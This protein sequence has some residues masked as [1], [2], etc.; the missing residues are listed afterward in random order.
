L[1]VALAFALVLASAQG[2]VLWDESVSGDLSNTQSSPTSIT[3][4]AGQNS[5]SGTVGLS[6]GQDWVTLTVPGGLQL[7]SLTLAVYA[8]S[9]TQGFIGV[10]S[11]SV[12]GGSPDNPASYLGYAHFGTAASNGALPTANLVGSDLLPIMGNTAAAPGS[13]GFTAPLGSGDYS[14]LIQ[15]LGAA[16]TYQFDY[17]VTPIPEVNAQ[18]MVAVLCAVLALVRISQ[19]GGALRKYRCSRVAVRGACGHQ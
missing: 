16:T 17:A 18:A 2:Q 9:D 13:Q 10:Q 11:S 14:F 3:L 19:R 4:S 7:N 12:F 6:D 5:L 1:P 8:S 15:Q